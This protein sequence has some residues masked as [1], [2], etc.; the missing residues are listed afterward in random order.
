MKSRSAKYWTNRN[1]LSR[2]SKNQLI[3]TLSGK[4]YDFKCSNK[5]YT[6]RIL[7]TNPNLQ[8]QRE[9]IDA[10]QSILNYICKKTLEFCYNKL[11]KWSLCP[12][13]TIFSPCELSFV[14]YSFCDFHYSKCQIVI[15]MVLTL[16]VCW[17]EMKEYVQS[18]K[19]GD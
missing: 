16:R 13:S 10:W 8:G 4:Q 2:N 3:I 5:R 17:K 6:S 7:L 1:I 9:D 11:W 15:I 12:S 19:H 18:F 14:N